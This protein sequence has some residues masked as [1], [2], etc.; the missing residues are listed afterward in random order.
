MTIKQTEKTYNENDNILTETH[1]SLFGNAWQMTMKFIFT[2]D[3]KNNILTLEKQNWN[4]IKLTNKLMSFFSYD[5]QNNLKTQIDKN[6]NGND[7]VEKNRYTYT[8]NEQNRPLTDL[9]EIMNN[10]EWKYESQSLL[11]YD[12]NNN[13]AKVIDQDWIENR[14]INTR[15]SLNTYNS[16]NK[17]ISS[18]DKDWDLDGITVISG[19][20]T[21]LYYS[22][23]PNNILII[24]ED[25]I[26]VFPNPS[27][28]KINVYAN[29]IIYNVKIYRL[30]GELIYTKFN[31]NANSVKIN[32]TNIQTNVYVLK[33]E[34]K[35]KIVNKKIVLQ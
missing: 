3:D 4:G 26:Y 27:A 7:W 31:I 34:Q 25:N 35:N 13:L 6:W 29:D 10:N 2:Y 18:S 8:Y 21:H 17:L 9:V 28:G 33:I 5:I 30:T 1:Q 15:T 22:E 12:V 24:K 14:W 16:S 19:D 20:S 23:L 11:N 32:L